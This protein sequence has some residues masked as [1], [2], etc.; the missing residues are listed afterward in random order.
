MSRARQGGI[1]ALKREAPVTAAF[2]E[3]QVGARAF[4]DVKPVPLLLEL[5]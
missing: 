4:P 2:P 3:R 5:R 1:A